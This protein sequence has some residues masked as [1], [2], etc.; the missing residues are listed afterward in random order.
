MVSGVYTLDVAGPDVVVYCDFDSEPGCG[1]TYI[2]PSTT[3][4]ADIS[5]LYTE[6]D[7]VVLRHLR[8]NGKQYTADVEQI[9]A[10][11]GVPLSVQFNK[12][13]GYRGP[14]NHHMNPYIY[15]GIV[16]ADSI[17]N[18]VTQ[19]WSIQGTDHTFTNCDRNPSSYFVFLVNGDIEP[20][21]TTSTGDVLLKDVGSAWVTQ[22]INADVDIPENFFVEDYELHFGGCGARLY[23]TYEF[24]GIGRVRGVALGLNSDLPVVRNG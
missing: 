3:S 6:N 22:A 5:S 20:Y 4:I 9:S 23:G 1:F 2:S 16:P 24:E 14:I 7:I 17:A 13:S 10:F 15:L 18:G 19:G 11:D 21:V 12:N 8:Q